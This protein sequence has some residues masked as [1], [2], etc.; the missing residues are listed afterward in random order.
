MRDDLAAAK[1][2]LDATQ[3][4]SKAY[5]DK[6]RREVPLAVGDDVLLNTKHLNLKTPLYR[7]RKLMPRYVGPFEVLERIGA[8]VYRLRLPDTMNRPHD[9][10]HVSLLKP[11]R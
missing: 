10:F 7:T 4:R 5:A 1:N 11:Y 8:V 6:H 2:A 9:V 3:Q